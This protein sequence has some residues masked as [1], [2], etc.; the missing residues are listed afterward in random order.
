M[1]MSDR[2]WHWAVRIMGHSNG[3]WVT[4]NVHLT[5]GNVNGQFCQLQWPS[6]DGTGAWASNAMGNW[7]WAKGIGWTLSRFNVHDHWVNGQ[8]QRTLAMAKA[9][10]NS[11]GQC[12]VVMGTR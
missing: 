1:A 2:Q 8:M 7:Q 6:G 12:A 9:I 5:M 11:K 3:E 4:G 10:C